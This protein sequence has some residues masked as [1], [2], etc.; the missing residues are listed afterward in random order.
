MRPRITQRLGGPRPVAGERTGRAPAAAS[1][2]GRPRRRCRRGTAPAP[3]RG[4]RR[5]RRA[6]QIT[7]SAPSD[8][9]QRGDARERRGGDKRGRGGDRR[10]AEPR[11]ARPGQAAA[12][13]RASSPPRPNSQARVGV[14]KYAAAGRPPSGRRVREARRGEAPIAIASH[15]RG[16]RATPRRDEQQQRP[17]QVELLLGRERP[18]V[19]HGGGR[20]RRRRSSRRPRGELP[21][22]D[23][24]RAGAD[25]REELRPVDGGRRRSSRARRRAGTRAPRAGSAAR[26]A[27]RSPQRD[28]AVAVDLAQQMRRDQVA[29][30]H[31]EHVDADEAAGQRRRPEW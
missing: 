15:R 18:E 17:H 10:Q 20:A 19:P 22:L 5:R 11:A 2:R 1:A 31:E 24:E 25:L 29:R 6:A 14:T 30:D 7:A 26:A 9:Q 27:P 16:A 21:V 12:G 4:A 8:R 13:A 28:A 23:V 3:R